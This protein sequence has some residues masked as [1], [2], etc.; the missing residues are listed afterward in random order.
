MVNA[1]STKSD[2]ISRTI[3]LLEYIESVKEKWITSNKRTFKSERKKIRSKTF[4]CEDYTETKMERSN[5]VQEDKR[6]RIEDNAYR[7]EVD[8]KYP[9]T[10]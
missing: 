3:L 8:L 6:E 5:E 10:L 4:H 7:A 9:R 1:T 2:I